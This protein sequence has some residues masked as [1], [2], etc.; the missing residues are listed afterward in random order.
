MKP[1][2]ESYLIGEIPLFDPCAKCIVKV[3][4]TRIC[5][6]KILFLKNYKEPNKVVATLK[7]RKR[8]KKK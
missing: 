8:R 2:N 6:E 5:K 4:C 1:I 7:L 3:C